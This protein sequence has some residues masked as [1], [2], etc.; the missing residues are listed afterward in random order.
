MKIDLTG[1]VALVTGGYGAI[2]AAMCEYYVNAGAAV[3]IVGRNA[4]RGEAF[5]A[6][7]HSMGGNAKYFRGDVSDKPCMEQVAADVIAHFGKIDILVNNAGVNVGPEGR[8]LI[9]EFDDSEWA[10]TVNIDLNGV[11]YTSK[12]IIKNMVENGYGRIINISSIVGEVPL[13]NQ[14]AFAAAKAGVVNLTKAMAIELAPFGIL[15][16]AICPGSIMFEG[17]RALF[18]ADKQRAERMI[19][20]IP[21]GRPGEPKEIAGMTIMMS[22]DEISYMTGNIVTID[23]GWICGFARDF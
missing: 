22:S 12:P 21:L 14:C 5:E 19:S 1:R 4:E 3:A 23:G 8:K 6:Q 10:R 16:N 11:Y 20:H 7:L 18:Y 2:G 13:R 15:V 9:H 17:T